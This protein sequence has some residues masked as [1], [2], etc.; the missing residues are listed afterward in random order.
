MSISFGGDEMPAESIVISIGVCVVFLLF[1]FAVAWAD[2]SVSQWL[3]DKMS[4]EQA[5]KP[6]HRKAV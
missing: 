2:H 1:A 3:R 5:E 4:A 6:P